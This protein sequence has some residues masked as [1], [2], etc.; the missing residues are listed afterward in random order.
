MR[1]PPH[2][3]RRAGAVALG[4]SRGP[5]APPAL[6]NPLAHVELSLERCECG[7]E[8]LVNSSALA[9]ELGPWNPPREGGAP[10]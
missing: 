6:Q 8:R 3:C 7:L 10:M 9:R 2:H 5:V 1:P 4:P